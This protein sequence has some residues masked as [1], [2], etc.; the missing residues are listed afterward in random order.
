MASLDLSGVTDLPYEASLNL[1]DS[2]TDVR[3]VLLPTQL[4]AYRVTIG[5]IYSAT[6]PASANESDGFCSFLSTLDD[7]D[8]APAEADGARRKLLKAGGNYEFVVPSATDAGGNQITQIAVWGQA[9]GAAEIVIDGVD[10][11]SR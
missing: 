6:P 8:A 5:P 11:P 7:D 3:V 9:N 1:Q 4:S 2:A 10:G